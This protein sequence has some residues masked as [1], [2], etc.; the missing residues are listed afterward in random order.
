MVMAKRDKEKKSRR[1]FVGG[2]MDGQWSED[3]AQRSLFILGDP[4]TPDVSLP[5]DWNTVSNP[6]PPRE[7]YFER[8]VYILG[9][10]LE[11]WVHDSVRG[12]AEVNRMILRSLFQRDVAQELDIW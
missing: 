3:P 8:K 5:V 6:E 9:Y 7:Q 11:V 2:S 4:P 12:E 1:L 10:V